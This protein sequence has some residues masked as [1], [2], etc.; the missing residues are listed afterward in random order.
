MRVTVKSWK[1]LFLFCL[2][3]AI[4]AAFCMKWMENDLVF[5]GEKFTILG[6]E[7]FYPAEKISAVLSGLDGH[8]K[9]ILRYHLSFD[10]AFMA[11]VY[12]GIS[13]LCIM[14]GGRAR[15]NLLR[16]MAQLLAAL[17]LLAWAG[18]IVEN[19]YLLQWINRPVAGDEFTSYHICVYMK[20]AIALA[21]ILFSIV[22][23]LRTGR[24]SKTI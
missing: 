7:L 18:D 24:R 19:Y 11:G 16:K 8:V 5:R 2:G 1:N 23:A 3:L 20:W 9:T 15:S 4:A 17:Q 21:G 22:V 6:L 10:F 13:A 12:P 14:V